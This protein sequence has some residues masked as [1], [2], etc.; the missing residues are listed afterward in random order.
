MKNLLYVKL[1]GFYFFFFASLGIII[2]YFS[3]YLKDQGFGP[4]QIG[5]V[6]GVIQ[7]T[8]IIAPNLWGWIADVSGRRTLVIKLGTLLALLCFSIIFIDPGYALLALIMAFFSFFWN[9]VLPQF[10]AATLVTLGEGV[11]R[12]T[13]IRLWGS[14]GFILSVVGLGWVFEHYGTES[15]PWFVLALLALLWLNAMLLRETSA[16][17]EQ[18]AGGSFWHILGN[19]AVL[20]LLISCF[21]MKASHGPY[22]AFYTIYL[23]EFGYSRVAAGQLWAVGVVAEIGIFLVMHRWIPRF[24]AWKLLLAAMLLTVVRWA[25]IALL[26]EST[27][28]VVAAQIL[29]AASF[30]VYHASAIQLIFQY[31]PGEL[32]GRGL[33]LYAS[34]SFGLGGALGSFASGYVWPSMGAPWVFGMG[35][36]LALAAFIT[37]AFGARASGISILRRESL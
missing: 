36:L 21:L 4:G 12:Y 28:A 18:A 14:I 26:V 20:A 29:H 15:L 16:E 22:Y 25:M 7:G 31:F 19:P 5:I 32:K 8:K 13:L 23:E 6:M 11:H 9:A 33:A 2:P 27:V 34:L 24:G 3:L 30:G 35:S 17:K 10:E 1:S 37:A